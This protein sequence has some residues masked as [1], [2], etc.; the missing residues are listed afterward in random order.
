MDNLHSLK[1]SKRIEWT[2]GNGETLNIY[3]KSTK[4]A[5][6]WMRQMLD[7]DSAEADFK[8]MLINASD[9]ERQ[10]ILRIVDKADTSIR[11]ISSSIN[12]TTEQAFN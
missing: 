3:F 6:A 11:P 4:G 12:N 10:D 2:T 9:D 5:V 1:V 8:K 7:R